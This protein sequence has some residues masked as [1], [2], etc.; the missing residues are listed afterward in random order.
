[1]TEHV[2]VYRGA[3]LA[4]YGFGE[5]HPFGP[6]R[7]DV[8]HD[9]LLEAGMDVEVSYADPCEADR[10]L[11]ALFHTDGYI[12]R[13]RRASENGTG[14]LDAGDTPAFRGVYEAAA[15]VAGTVRDAVDAIMTGRCT[16]SFVP[17]AGLHH[18]RR[19]SAGGFCVFN[20]CGIAIEYLRAEYG[21]R[22]VAYVDIDAHHGDGVFYGFEDDPDLV[23]ADIHEDGRFLYPG[24]GHRWETGRG[25]AKD[26]KLNVPMP[27]SA[28]DSVFRAAWS[29]V[30]AYIGER[31]PEFII[32][33]CG[34][35]AMAGDPITHLAYSE[36]SYALAATRLA[37]YAAEQCGGRLLAT[38]GGGYNRP[39][40]ARA[41]R[42]VVRSLLDA[43]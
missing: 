37:R 35:D 1:M 20:D 18:A 32:L 36:A 33:Q 7:H 31:R 13:V 19:D 17:I 28:D 10:E 40:L 11:I 38:G 12:D 21:L 27:P 43:R 16:A 9:G 25:A 42:T 8:F 39:N 23:F 26:T 14:W 5:D 15:T 4:R 29:Q 3:A 34:A 6:D 22:R 24:T 30:E 2:R 41:W